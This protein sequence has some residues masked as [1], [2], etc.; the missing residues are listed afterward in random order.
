MIEEKFTSLKNDNNQD[1]Q[2]TNKGWKEMLYIWFI[3]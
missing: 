2:K 1:P 3:Q